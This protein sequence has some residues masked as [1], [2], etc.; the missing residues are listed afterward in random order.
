MELRRLRLENFRQFAQTEIEFGQGITGVVGPNGVGKTTLLEAIAWAI[1]G[2]PAVRGDK[3]SIRRHGAP[4][5]SRVGV[6]LEFRLGPHEY[7]V[8]RTLYG[9]ELTQDGRVVATPSR[10]C[11]TSSSGS[12]ACRT[13]SSSIPTSPVRRSWR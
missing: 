6:T 8:D 12:W 13:P 11:P 7:A 3:D 10:P 4:G 2:V 1:Y 5:R 9:A